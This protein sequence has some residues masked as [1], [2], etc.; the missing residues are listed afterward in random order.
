LKKFLL[1]IQIK[2]LKFNKLSNMLGGVK[3]NMGQVME[4]TEIK[5][6]NMMKTL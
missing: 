1:L 6:F 4:S 2:E 3:L 5:K